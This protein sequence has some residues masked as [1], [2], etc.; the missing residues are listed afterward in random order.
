MLLRFQKC[1]ND[2]ASRGLDVDLEDVLRPEERHSGKTSVKASTTNYDET[3]H[4]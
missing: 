3:G 4:S 2:S 1:L